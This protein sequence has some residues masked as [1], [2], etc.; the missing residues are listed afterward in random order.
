MTTDSRSMGSE[1]SGQVL[2]LLASYNCS[3]AYAG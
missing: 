2:L 1:V 3:S